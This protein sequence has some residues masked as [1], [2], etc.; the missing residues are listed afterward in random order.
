VMS[1]RDEN[2]R[3]YL[4]LL[5]RFGFSTGELARLHWA[6]SE[7]PPDVPP[8][9]IVAHRIDDE[10]RT[11]ESLFSRLQRVL[12]DS[13]IGMELPFGATPR[14]FEAAV[15]SAF[16]KQKVEIEMEPIAD[17]ALEAAGAGDP[18]DV[19]LT[20][21][22]GNT[23][24]TTDTYPDPKELPE[25]IGVLERELLADV[26]VTFVRLEPAENCDRILLLSEPRFDALRETYGER[27]SF[28]D[29]PLFAERHPTDFVSTGA[30]ATGDAVS[31]ESGEPTPMDDAESEGESSIG[32][33]GET[34]STADDASETESNWLTED[35]I[36]LGDVGFEPAS[37]EGTPSESTDD[38]SDEVA[39][40]DIDKAFAEIESA[41]SE[42]DWGEATS[43]TETQRAPSQ[44]EA[45]PEPTPS[46][47]DEVLED[48]PER[49]PVE[50]T[51]PKATDQEVDEGPSE[52]S[53]T[54]AE[55][56]ESGETSSPSIVP[57]RNPISA[58]TSIDVSPTEDPRPATT[59]VLAPSDRLSGSSVDRPRPATREISVSPGTAP[60]PAVTR[61]EDLRPD[62]PDSGNAGEFI[63]ETGSD[64][65]PDVIPGDDPEQAAE[66]IATTPGT[67][68]KSAVTDVKV[69]PATEVT[70]AIQRRS[71]PSPAVAPAGSPQ[72]AI[73]RIEFLPNPS[74]IPATS[75]IAVTPGAE[76][77]PAITHQGETLPITPGEDPIPAVRRRL[78]GQ[79]GE[80]SVP[81][82]PDSVESSQAEPSTAAVHESSSVP[83]GPAPTRE[84]IP[85]DIDSEARESEP[86]ITP[87]DS[88]TSAVHR[89]EVTP[90]DDPADAVIWA[91]FVY[92][93]KMPP[94]NSDPNE[95]GTTNEE[96]K[97]VVERLSG[98]LGDRL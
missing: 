94:S 5:R 78:P 55:A 88:P 47:S 82:E 7:E 59:E 41:A 15:Q 96:S 62:E 57:G 85:G 58:I 4:V 1:D 36:D 90:G 65:R 49:A 22:H 67:K 97:G 39:Q 37:A 2:L 25:L 86:A 26:D 93:P 50:V 76:P 75:R 42:M 87:G 32:A 34:E 51:D 17:P 45:E 3:D 46:F 68:V 73:T 19:I 91:P 98:W 23:R 10:A 53:D 89:I 6:E 14:E 27:V 16:Q 44:V 12:A 38:G 48:G 9:R 28:S 61:I 71:E 20:D 69:R 13:N 31:D 74:P 77:S 95:D 21:R 40:V 84:S 18:I 83:E 33:E 60:A 29:R 64:P 79:D 24:S 63:P 8:E 30:G 81:A 92:T 80:S 70:P 52:S 54:G 66:S 11:I 72:P 56:R 43:E 35:A